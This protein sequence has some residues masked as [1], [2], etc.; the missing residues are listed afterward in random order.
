MN[1]GIVVD[2]HA[3]RDF[4][5]SGVRPQFELRRHRR[6]ILVDDQRDRQ[7][8]AAVAGRKLCAQGDRNDRRILGA[9]R[10]FDRDHV[11]AIVHRAIV[12]D[13]LNQAGPRIIR[14]GGRRRRHVRAERG[15]QQAGDAE[16]DGN[17][18]RAWSRPSL[19]GGNG[20][21]IR[22]CG[23]Y[24]HSISENAAVALRAL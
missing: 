10:H 19:E 8:A 17:D 20:A 5:H 22:H 1:V 9:V 23:G 7:H 12:E 24:S 11:A 16:A 2:A 3:R 21:N 18:V 6:R 13:V 15:A 14:F 4:R